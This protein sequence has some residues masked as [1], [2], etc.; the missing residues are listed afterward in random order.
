VGLSGKQ[1]QRA[2]K[3]LRYEEFLD[4]FSSPDIIRAKLDETNIGQRFSTF[5]RPPPGKFFFS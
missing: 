3:K 4:S 1:Y 2:E 5:V